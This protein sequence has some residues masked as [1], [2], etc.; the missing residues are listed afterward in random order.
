MLRLLVKKQMTEIFR[1]YFYDARKNRARSKLQIAGFLVMFVAI[2]LVVLGGIFSGLSLLL[3]RPLTDAGLAWLYFSIMGLISILLGTFG[4]VFNTFACLYLPKDNDL[5]LSLPIP[6]GV[7]MTSRLITVYLLGVMYSGV[8]ILPAVLVHAILYTPTAGSLVGGAVLMLL[9]SVFVLTLSCVLGRVVAGISLKMK[10]KSLITVVVSILFICGYYF[11][12]MRAQLLLQE[13]LTNAA[14]YGAKIKGAA[15][16]LYLFGRMGTGDGRAMLIC[17][18][19]VACL[20]ALIWLLLSRSFL[21][22]A[23]ASGHSAARVY[24]EKTAK[25]RSISRALLAKEIGRFLGSPL[26]ILN[27]G[28]GTLLLPVAG[29]AML[30]K[31]GPLI[32]ILDEVF[33]AQSGCTPLLLCALVCIIASM[34]DMATPAFSLEGKSLWLLQSLPVSPGQ[35]LRAKLMLQLVLTMPAACFC[36]I[37]LRFVYAYTALEFALS[38]LVVLACLLLS[39]LLSL[40]IGLIT[41]NVNWVSEVTPIKQNLGVLFALLGSIVYVV[42]LCAGFLLPGGRRPGFAVYMGLVAGATLALC[43]LLGLWLRHRGRERF[44]AL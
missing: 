7:L 24:K 39:A 3:C 2:M 10:N 25:Q 13:L 26:Y 9:I 33:G 37:C 43:A 38:A 28:L 44:A 16:P 6:T 14:V 35:V 11:F 30:W 1:A 32:L 36:L 21:R 40:T 34:N 20:F 15:W 42:L 31:G 8:V 18:A 41:A 19:V 23:T 12:V 17:A 29:I 22:I 27:C 4:S 5:M